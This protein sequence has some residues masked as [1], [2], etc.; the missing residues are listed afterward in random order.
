[1]AA[2][3]DAQGVDLALASPQQ[4]ADVVRKET[5]VWD[6]VIRDAKITLN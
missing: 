1:M 4:L 3:F 5:A 6:K 2:R